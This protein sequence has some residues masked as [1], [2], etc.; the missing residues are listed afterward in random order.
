M[1]T[2]TIRSPGVDKLDGLDNNA[3]VT[4]RVTRC[5]E[6]QLCWEKKKGEAGKRKHEKRQKFCGTMCD[7][8]IKTNHQKSCQVPNIRAKQR[9]KST[10]YFE[11]ETT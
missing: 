2:T 8:M 7:V 5:R 10:N 4:T 9:P 3:S 6:N 11:F 1:A